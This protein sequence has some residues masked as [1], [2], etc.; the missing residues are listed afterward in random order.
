LKNGNILI[1]GG[2]G[3]GWTFL[4]NAEIYNPRTGAF[5]ATGDM[6]TERESHTATLLNDG[7][8]LITGGHKDRRA[9]ITRYRSAEIYDPVKGSFTPTGDLNVKRHKHEA[10]LLAD[11][12]VLIIGGSDE[13]DGNGAYQNA[14]VFDSVK[15]TFAAVE[16]SMKTARYKLQGT[17]ILLRNGKVLIAGGSDRAEV[18]DPASNSF[19]LAGG[20]F[21]TLRLFATATLLPN[22]KV[23]ITGGYHNGNSISDGAWIFT[24]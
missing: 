8:V 12:R 4:K 19:S 2:V 24:V 10:T 7:R 13:R 22:G 18:F 15:G 1:A 9:N 16:N 3:T 23:L 6:S 20:D 17:A 14:E 5:S 11:G 21:G